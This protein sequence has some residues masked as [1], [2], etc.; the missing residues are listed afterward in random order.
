MEYITFFFVFCIFKKFYG[1]KIVIFYMIAELY[2]FILRWY[3]N[4]IILSLVEYITFFSYFVS[5]KLCDL[6]IVILYTIAKN[7]IFIFTLQNITVIAQ[8]LLDTS[9]LQTISLLKRYLE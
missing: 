7:F 1:L 6:K 5:K 3:W 2:I 8:Q 9:R 4:T